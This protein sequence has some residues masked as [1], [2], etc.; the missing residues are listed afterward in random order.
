MLEL[1]QLENARIKKKYLIEAIS[2]D[3]GMWMRHVCRQ[4]CASLSAIY[5]FL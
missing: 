4:A 1:F 3:F 5:Q 2:E